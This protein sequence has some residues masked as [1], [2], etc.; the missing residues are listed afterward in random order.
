[1]LLVW[2]GLLG[3]LLA[4]G[5]VVCAVVVVV[6]FGSRGGARVVGTVGNSVVVAGA[7]SLDMAVVAGDPV[8]AVDVGA[9]GADG[10][11]VIEVHAQGAR[12]RQAVTVRMVRRAAIADS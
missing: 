2:T 5:C 8:G 6:V 12:A 4:G 1:M 3:R 7:G 9:A 10:E 11:A